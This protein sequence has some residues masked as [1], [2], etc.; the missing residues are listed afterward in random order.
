MN[1]VKEDKKYSF[2]LLNKKSGIKN[3]KKSSSKVPSGISSSKALNTSPKVNKDDDGTFEKE[4]KE[5]KRN[6]KYA[7]TKTFLRRINCNDL[8]IRASTGYKIRPASCLA[9]LEFAGKKNSRIKKQSQNLLTPEVISAFRAV[10]KVCKS[11][12]N[13]DYKR[14]YDGAG[15]H[16]YAYSRNMREYI[17]HCTQIIN[18]F[19]SYWQK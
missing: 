10:H 13:G 2:K 1:G 14:F 12:W 7:D 5:S 9:F 19:N 16:I 6:K 18:R 15:I 8:A 3:V 11:S 4:Y 17:S